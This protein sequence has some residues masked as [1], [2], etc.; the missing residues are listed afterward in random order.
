MKN[1]IFLIGFLF[2]L[3]IPI[4]FSSAV[5]TPSI[6]SQSNPI[7]IQ[8]Q[9]N[10]T[11]AWSDAWRKINSI[12]YVP[13]CASIY[14]T[15][16][17]QSALNVDMSDPASVTSEA[18]YLNYLYSSYQSCVSRSAQIQSH[19]SIENIQCAAGLVNSNGVCVTRD[20]SCNTRW[21]N[22]IWTGETND[23]GGSICGCKTGYQW[24]EQNT[25]CVVAPVVSLKTNDQICNEDYGVNSVWSNT[26]NDTGGPICDCKIG[27]EWDS[28]GTAC[29][30]TTK[31]ETKAPIPV[32]KKAP[33][34]KT[35][36]GQIKEETSEVAKSDPVNVEQKD[37]ISTEETPKSFWARLKG[38]LGF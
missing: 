6:G 36:S 7:Y 28:E 10:P 35:V 17:S 3:L 11:Q 4:H 19:Q 24:N 37:T 2:S 26:L 16:N 38:W 18:T 13:A 8:V 14:R 29:M 15:I 21:V 31:T 25:S 5:Y 34:T 12:Q 20:V 9:Q 30:A 1:K 27:Y 23:Q 22:S 32:I 33:E